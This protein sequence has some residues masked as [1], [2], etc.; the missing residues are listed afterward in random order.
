MAIESA[1]MTI[2]ERN[3][4]RWAE[5]LLRSLLR[6]SDR[7]SIS[8]DLLE[9]YRAVR[10]PVLGAFWATAWYVQQSLS[11]LWRLMWPGLLALTGVTLLS[12]KVKALGYPSLVPAPLVSLED[13]L[14][15]L[16]VGYYASRRTGLIRT[17]AI[18]AGATS[19]IGFTFLFTSVA[20]TNPGLLAAPFGKPF[21]FV[22]LSVMTLLALGV[23][24]VAGILGSVI[25]KWLAP[26]SP[27]TIPA[28]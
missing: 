10:H 2:T 22:I 23:G 5:A 19:F 21:I 15:Y 8:G 25:G 17:G 28:S 7:E 6:P 20:I 3:P 12:L 1:H 4:P 26:V 18:V 9:E 14:V 13:A 16:W 24:V 27:Q 11:V